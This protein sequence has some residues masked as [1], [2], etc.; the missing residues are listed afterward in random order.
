M[1]NGID[2]GPIVRHI[3]EV[4]RVL[5]HQI[6]VVNQNVGVIDGKVEGV[7]QDQRVTKNRLNE[8]YAEFEAFVAADL[9]H[10]AFQYAETKLISLRQELEKQFGH[11]DGVRRTAVGILQATDAGLV[12]QETMHAV[13]EQ[14]MLAT[15]R[16][17]LAPAIVALSAWIKDDR[18]LAEKAMAEALRREDGK[19]SLFFALVCRRGRRA[20]AATRWLTRYFQIQNPTAM[21]REVVVMLDGLANGVFGGGALV[22][23]S[24]V[25]EQWLTELGAMAGFADQQRRRWAEKL[26]VMARTPRATEY[27]TLRQYSPSAPSLMASLGAARRNQVV[28]AFFADLFT[29]ELVLSPAIEAAVDAL[30]DSL[31]TNFDDEELPLQR[32]KRQCELIVDEKGDEEAATRRFQAEHETFEAQTSFA[33]LLTSSAMTPETLG[34]TRATQRYAV[35]RSRQW[36]LAAHHDLVA[37]DRAA[38]LREISITVA[39][40]TGTSVDGANEAALVAEVQRHFAARIEAALAPI[41]LTAGPWIALVV[42]GLFGGLLAFQG[43]V[44]ILFGL[45]IG[46]G[47]AAFFHWKRLEIARVR[48]AT[49]AALETERD[50]TI[51]ILKACL[52]ELADYRREVWTED[53][54]SEQVSTLLVSLSSPQFMLQRP[55]QRV[56][57]A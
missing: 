42:G 18:P 14:L 19:T 36:I 35:S 5:G 23:C 56:A 40:W 33:A 15:P 50:Q 31:V 29:G 2:L 3:S 43:G 25:I 32:A 17:W 52:A 48:A 55:D 34:A 39:S 7:A 1:S 53:A 9:K 21:D 41:Q 37:R 24:T 27:P 13:T 46:G 47:A 28:H 22:A 4:G 49:Q 57:V 30:L 10:K 16:Y 44:A 51:R 26:G 11:H 45:L 20:E 38:L 8:L 12:R 54:K 6:D